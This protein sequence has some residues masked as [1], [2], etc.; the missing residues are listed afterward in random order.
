ML[1]RHRF[2]SYKLFQFPFWLLKVYDCIIFYS[3]LFFTVLNWHRS[4]SNWDTTPVRKPNRKSIGETYHRKRFYV[5]ALVFEPVN[6]G[7]HPFRSLRFYAAIPSIW[8]ISPWSNRQQ[9]PDLPPSYST[10]EE[11]SNFLILSDFKI[12]HQSI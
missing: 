5:S 2:V 8:E 9:H 4:V 11:H 3:L 1:V 12:N 6:I 7:H 10:M